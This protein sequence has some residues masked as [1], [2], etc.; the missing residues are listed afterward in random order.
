MS[1]NIYHITFYGIVPDHWTV[2][3]GSFADHSYIL[4]EDYLSDGI[5]ST[6]SSWATIG[7]PLKF[8][9]PQ[10][11]K[12]TY[13]IEG[14]AQGQLTYTSSGSDGYVK[15]YRVTI[16]KVNTDT[17]ETELFSTGWVTVNK[18]IDWDSSNSIGDEI[19]FPFW[20]DCW[21]HAKLEENDRIYVKIETDTDGN[22]YTKIYHSNDANWE[23]FKIDIPFRW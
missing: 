9:Y 21:E 15:A 10:H 22:S 4:V 19:V 7:E 14:V 2:T 20:I 6:P 3:F 18:T 5:D 1:D 13:F 16:C 8:I 12:K 23:D 17:T 11:L